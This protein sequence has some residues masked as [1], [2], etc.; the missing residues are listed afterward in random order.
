MAIE[1]K[2]M[3]ILLDLST[4]LDVIDNEVLLTCL[5]SRMEMEGDLPQV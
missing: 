1:N 5:Q 2:S 3:L 4:V